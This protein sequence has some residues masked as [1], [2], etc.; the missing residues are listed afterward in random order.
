MSQLL[1]SVGQSIRASASA[2]VL[3]LM[4]GEVIIKNKSPANSLGIKWL[5]LCA[6][7]AKGPG[8]NP[9]QGDKIPQAS[10]CGQKK[11]KKRLLPILKKLVLV[12]ATQSCLTLRPHGL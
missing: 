11:K 8:P 7:I 5:R 4:K 10:R 1:A 9:V 6:F 3:P 2:S 12:L